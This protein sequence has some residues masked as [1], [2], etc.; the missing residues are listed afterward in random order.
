MDIPY[1]VAEEYAD[2]VHAIFLIESNEVPLAIGDGWRALGL[3][4]QHPSMSDGLVDATQDDISF[5]DKC[6]DWVRGEVLP[7][8]KFYMHDNRP[9]KPIF[10][11]GL[12]SLEIGCSVE[13]I[14]LSTDGVNHTLLLNKL[15][16]VY[17]E[18]GY[19]LRS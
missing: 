18:D 13:R 4:Q 5:F 19:G 9:Y 1:E 16:G 12:H 8:H 6:T 14:N 17:D 7:S 2:W 11:K 10:L 3:G 15:G